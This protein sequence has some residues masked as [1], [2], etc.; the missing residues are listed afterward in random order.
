MLKET[1]NIYSDAIKSQA[2]NRYGFDPDCLKPLEGF[3]NFVYAC[4]T[5]AGPRIL[6]VTHSLHRP[7]A[8]IQGEVTWVNN[9]A[10]H[11]MPVAPAIPSLGGNLTEI[12]PDEDSGTYFTVVTF[13]WAPGV[14]LDD[15]PKEKAKYWNGALF[16]QWGRVL[17]QIHNHAQYHAP[18]LDIQRSHWHEYDVLDLERFIPRE[19]T[20]VLEVAHSHLAKLHTLPK[21]PSVYGL[22]HAD[23]TQWNFNVDGDG[24][25]TVFDFDSTEYG[26]FIKDLAVSLYY[27][28][29]SHE[30]NNLDAFNQDF[31]KHLVTGYRQIRP[32]SDDWLG[33]IPDF[34][35]LQR[36]I[37]YSYCHQLGDHVNPTEEN[38]AYL[39]KTRKIIESGQESIKLD[40]S[41]L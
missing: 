3:E 35:F 38:L 23:L 14:I 40:F 30:G 13:A 18:I 31:I 9:M 29:A 2:A 17:G 11:G 1:E 24:M 28:Y 36:I 39:E 7:V 32:I 15:H 8:H 19:Q 4:D 27:A 41:G 16:E 37:L 21:S 12:I 22:T 6:R 10:E 34:L 25:I 5:K 33:Y 20:R 26:W